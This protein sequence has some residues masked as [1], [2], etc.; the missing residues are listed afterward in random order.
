MTIRILLISAIVLMIG[1]LDP[2]YPEIES[3]EVDILVVDGGLDTSTGD[4]SVTLSQ[5]VAL[6]EPDSF[7]RVTHALVSIEDAQG[8]VYPLS[9]KGDGSYTTSGI[10]VFDDA[11]YRLHVV[12]PGDFEYYSDVVSP[13]STPPID[14]ITWVTDDNQLTIR[15]NAHDATG[16]TRYYRWSYDETWNYHSSTLSLYKVV[17][18][19]IVART[20]EEIYFYCWRTQSSSSII[21]NSTS[22]L[23]EDIVSQFPLHY[24]TAGSQKFQIKYSIL[25]RQQAISEDEY[26]YLEQL[27]KTTESI[28]GLFDPQPGQVTGNINRVKA[29]APIAVGYFSATNTV[30]KR[31]FIN[32]ETLPLAFRE[33][34]PRLGCNPPDTV[35]V[36]PNA[37]RCVINSTELT[38]GYI[39]GISLKDD[40]GFT[41]T[42]VQCS[43]CRSEGGVLTKPDYWP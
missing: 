12:T 1:C 14:S 37:F 41:L 25:V 10:P 28:G 21:I 18:K 3:G 43:D 40:A 32:N 7:A 13:R 8:T 42:N 35:C 15:V 5:G 30:S 33:I 9:D 39:I 26:H 22:R 31:I 17:G 11:G 6:S 24:I 2:Y 34:W 16:Q 19:S 27:K 29:N 36:V 23:R 4:A 38:E 20:P